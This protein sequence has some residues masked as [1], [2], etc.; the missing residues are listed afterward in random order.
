M[1]DEIGTTTLAELRVL[2]EVPWWQQPDVLLNLLGL[3]LGTAGLYFS[4]RAF[5]EARKAASAATA[6]GQAVKIYT[7]GVELTEAR[8]SLGK[9][10]K[11]IHYEEARGLLQEIN[12]RVRRAIVPLDKIDDLQA[13]VKQ[14]RAM[15]DAA[16]QQ[17]QAVKPPDFGKESDAP[18]SVY[19]ALEAGFTTINNLVADL[20]GAI[21]QRSQNPGA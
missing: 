21:D 1:A 20:L 8:H 16:E 11:T 9:L 12:A 10:H 6:A 18:F 4:V 14:L 3:V 2:L 19:T 7:V 5:A 17:L 15:L 13:R